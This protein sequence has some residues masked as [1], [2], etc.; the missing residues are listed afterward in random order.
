LRDIWSMT[1]NRVESFESFR[2]RS[3]RAGADEVLERRWSPGQTVDTHSH[4][5]DAQALVTEGEMWLTFGSDT[6]HLRAGDTF[7]VPPGTPHSERYG[8]QGAAY[9][10]ARRNSR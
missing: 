4:E 9:W 7:H 2:T 6:Q 3:L 10:V 1:G 5:F 8:P